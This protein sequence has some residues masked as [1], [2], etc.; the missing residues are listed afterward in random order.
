MTRAS[1][2]TVVLLFLSSPIGAQQ[3]LVELNSHRPPEQQD[4]PYLETEVA[5]VPAASVS[6]TECV[7]LPA[8]SHCETGSLGSIGAD[9][10]FYRL[11]V[12]PR[13]HTLEHFGLVTLFSM[14]PGSPTALRFLAVGYPIDMFYAET[15]EIRRTKF[16]TILAIR[17]N[18]D[19][20][21]HWNE[22]YFFVWRRDRWVELDNSW[23]VPL[24]PCYAIEKGFRFDLDSWQAET[25]VWLEGRGAIG[26]AVIDFAVRG[27]RIDVTKVR[28]T[29]VDPRLSIVSTPELENL[30]RECRAREKKK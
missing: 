23:R 27:T 4:T 11:A 14:R 22:D 18:V 13:D 6:A 12:E 24:P 20:T 7:D 25:P 1:F 30:L 16:G 19:G 2:A 21:G 10:F 3:R 26:S 17:L 29:P 28:H 9:A 15:P 5:V 8:A